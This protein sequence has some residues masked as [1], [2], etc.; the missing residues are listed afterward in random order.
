VPSL[1]I[2]PVEADQVTAVL[3]APLTLAVKRSL[4][5]DAID[6]ELGETLTLMLEAKTLI[7]EPEVTVFPRESVADSL[8]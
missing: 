5:E 7:W 4:P 6:E 2:V 8:K 3:L 1:A